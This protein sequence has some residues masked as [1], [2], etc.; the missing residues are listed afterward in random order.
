MS[1]TSPTPRTRGRTLL[2]GGLFLALAAGCVLGFLRLFAPKEPLPVLPPFEAYDRGRMRSAMAVNQVQAELDTVLNCGSRFVGQKGCRAV[3]QLLRTTMTGAGLEILDQTIR[4]AAPHTLERQI[5]A[6]NG[7]PLAGVEVYP[8][9]PNHFQPMLTPTN[10]LTGELVLA[11]DELLLTRPSFTNCIAVVDLANPPKDYGASWTRYAQIGFQA[12]IVSHQDGL[13]AWKWTSSLGMVAAS[14]V[15]FVRL[16]ASERIFEHL[17]E[18]VT[19]R[20]R[21]EW[22]DTDNT[23]LVGRLRAPGHADEAVVIAANYDAPSYLPDLAPGAVPAVAVAAQLALIK[24][25]A[26]Y[27]NELKRDVIV[28]ATT[29]NALA[30]D[31]IARFLATLG[32]GSDP[33]ATRVRLEGEQK[34]QRAALLRLR[35]LLKCFDDATFFVDAERTAQRLDQLPTDQREVL[36]VELRY[37]LNTILLERSEQ[38]MTA[39]VAFLQTGH[40]EVAGPEFRAFITA[41]Q[42]YDEALAIAGFPPAKLLVTGRRFSEQVD[43]RARWQQRLADLRDYESWRV[44][45]SETALRLNRLFRSYRRFVVLSADLTPARTALTDRERFTFFMGDNVESTGY[46][47]HPVI[48]DLLQSMYQRAGLKAGLEY[49][50]LAPSHHS[51]VIAPK[52]GGLP[53]DAAIWNGLSYPA[54]TLVNTD[55]AESYQQWGSP[56]VAPFM[57]DLS[58]LRYSLAALGD[59]ALSLA[60]GNGS[61]L[62]PKKALVH[63]FGGCAYVANVGQSIVPNYPLAGALF[64]CKLGNNADG[65]MGRLSQTL[66]FTDPY[67]RYWLPDWSQSVSGGG[68]YS[69]EI[70]GF[71]PDGL[72]R[73]VKD[74]GKQGQAVYQ[75]MELNL[76][77]ASPDTVNV[78]VFRAAPVTLLDLINPQT[79]QDYAAVEFITRDGLAPLGRFNSFQGGGA[80][81]TFIE[82]D[83]FFYVK[84]KA[85]SP[86]NP[87]VQTTRAFALGSGEGR[88]KLDPKK[89]IDGL[90]FLALATPLL[91]DLPVRVARS[92]LDVNGRRL[93]LQERYHMADARARTFQQKALQLLD[94]TTQPNLPARD[95]LLVGRD[96][97]TYATLNHPVLRESIFEAVVGILWYLGLLVPFVFFFEKLAFGFPDIRKQLLAQA[98]LFLVVFALLKLLHPAFAMIRSSMMILLGFVIMLISGGITVLFSGKFQENLEELRKRQAKV[99]AAEVNTLGVIGTAFM[100]G[101]NNMHRRKVRTGLTC[102]TLV[103]MTFAMICFTSLHSRLVDTALPIGKAPFQ[104]FLI[105]PDDFLPLTSGE[106]FALQTKYGQHY[107]VSSRSLFV[108][109][110]TWEQMQFNPEFEIVH[111]PAAGHATKFRFQSMLIFSPEEP[112]Q[113]RIKLTTT[114]G[115]FTVAQLRQTDGPAPVIIP[116]TMARALGVTVDQ[117]NRGG[118]TTTINGKSFRVHGIFDAES[119]GSLRDLDGRNLLPFDIEGMVSVRM[120]PQSQVLAGD[121]DPRISPE[122]VVLTVKDPGVAVPNGN[123]RLVSATVAL[124]GQPYKSAKAVVDQYLEQSGKPVYYGLGAV[125]YLGRRTRETS[126]AGL[127][128][129]V[130]PLIIA[131]LTV[132]NTMRGSVYERKDEILVY[133]AVGI[134]PRYVFFIFFAEAFVYA[135]VGS[136]LGYILSQGIGLALTAL[137]WTGGMNMTF[138]SL[139]TIF[140]SLA[141]ATAVFIST[142]FPARSAMRI[143]TPADDLG[144]KL[145]E[146]TGDTMSFALPFTFDWHDRVAVLS[147]F[148]RYFLD[149]GEG[150]AGKFFAGQPQL[151]VSGQTDA[152]ADGAYIPQVKTTIWLKPFDLGVSQDIIVELPT[153]TE[154][155]EYIARITLTRLSGTREAWIRLN[156]GFVMLVRQH[157]LHWRAVTPAER[158]E[159]FTESERLLAALQPAAETPA[160]G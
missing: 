65:A 56:C 149:H 147:F 143:A 32:P 97:V 66:S 144:W 108:G 154:T 69:P 136:V 29:G 47:Q 8:F 45:Q 137:G 7:Q 80:I 4:S 122:K 102:A 6:A 123:L 140:A 109:T 112:L 157:F 68:P 28:L 21:T 105:K 9:W 10:G 70:V 99:S 17:G 64:G 114:N 40:P 81:T 107:Q 58:S 42:R 116:D 124:P 2:V 59:T 127:L 151:G 95:R 153:D 133:N 37:V 62:P 82:P 131:A 139:T 146:P 24:G 85:G 1:P 115:W 152:L 53:T 128:G 92:M 19:L 63:S 134:A 89:E 34:T 150:S 158:A 90:G 26:P 118:V 96:A 67:G 12:I 126:L 41:K 106:L 104:G 48:N 138:T 156:Q 46:L 38:Q 129:V 55:R 76:M 3:E 119:F 71:G 148:H 88:Y 73:F 16:A 36:T 49:D 160:Q 75:S 13:A 84:L 98:I 23:S 93:A 72:I 155:R 54:F 20:V 145:P 78:V 94:E 61:F 18:T 159:M 77:T 31:G 44:E 113:N 91:Q 25:L 125:T 27:R 111:A 60:F 51:N 35:A 117:V 43:L 79:L 100:L 14:P 141:I 30:Y 33:D 11:T 121:N 22:R 57:R 132:L 86:E 103:L 39:N 83:Q 101:L 74:Q 15:N 52:L 110:R 142:W 50:P 5:L 120:T 130:I 87:L 135:V